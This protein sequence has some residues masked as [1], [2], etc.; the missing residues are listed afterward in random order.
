MTDVHTAR[1]IHHSDGT[2][3]RQRRQTNSPC[4]RTSCR[5]ELP[6]YLARYILHSA[7]PVP[8][9]ISSSICIP[10]HCIPN[11]VARP[12][13]TVLLVC[14]GLEVVR[15]NNEISVCVL[16]C[17]VKFCLSRPARSDLAASNRMPIVYT[18]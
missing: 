8:F 7:L 4:A 17:Y 10:A 15:Q 12:P 11:I 9:Y 1:K 14:L 13:V 2:V 16:D 3:K 6:N 18:G 5:E